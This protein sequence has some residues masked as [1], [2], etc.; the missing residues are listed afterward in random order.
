[1][2]TVEPDVKALEV[3]L[4][5]HLV[6]EVKDRLH[7]I[8]DKEIED[9]ARNAVIKFLQFQIDKSNMAHSF[10]DTYVFNFVQNITKTAV[11]TIVVKESK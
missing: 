5:E 3:I 2:I 6:K 9:I 11:K 10:S 7:E 4:K 8:V 1:M